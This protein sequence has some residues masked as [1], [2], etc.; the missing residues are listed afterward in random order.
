MRYGQG[1]TGEIDCK[2]G[3]VKGIDSALVRR[4][5]RL[6][7]GSPEQTLATRNADSYGM[8]S[9]ALDLSRPNQSVGK[10]PGK[11]GSLRV[12]QLHRLAQRLASSEA[13]L[14]VDDG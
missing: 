7:N 2:H 1:M 10:D 5:G 4:A 13:A 3:Q 14:R 9:S 11:T 6:W 12:A 8:N